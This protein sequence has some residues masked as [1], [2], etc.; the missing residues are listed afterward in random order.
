MLQSFL[1]SFTILHASIAAAIITIAIV[2]YAGFFTGQE[3]GKGE[4]EYLKENPFAIAWIFVGSLVSIMVFVGLIDSIANGYGD[5]D[6][7]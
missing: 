1:K 5:G 6:I 3:K 4:I 7:F 2:V